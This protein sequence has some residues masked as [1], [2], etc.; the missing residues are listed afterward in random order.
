MPMNYLVPSPLITSPRFKNTDCS[1]HALK[2]P[3][4]GGCGGRRV[5]LQRTR[6]RNVLLH[7][8]PST[9]K[10]TPVVLDPGFADREDIAPTNNSKTAAAR[11][12]AR[13]E[14]QRQRRL[15]AAARRRE[16]RARKRA[17][18]LAK[19]KAVTARKGR[20]KKL[21]GYDDVGLGCAHDGMHGYSDPD[22]ESLLGDFELAEYVAQQLGEY[23]ELP[24]LGGYSDDSWVDLGEYGLD[25]LGELGIGWEGI[26][27]GIASGVGST[28]SQQAGGGGGAQKV[29][30]PDGTQA[31]VLKQLA[32]TQQQMQRRQ[33]L[34]SSRASSSR[35]GGL[36]GATMPLVIA[37]GLLLVMTMKK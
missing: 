23:G 12:A 17:A 18:T 13:L 29:T 19:R 4:Q 6:K 36:G 15:N 9:G 20:S 24:E 21:H 5:R 16:A 2:F 31:L 32:S 11:R 33:L 26:V 10:V 34:D 3:R 25:D 37:G 35:S 1:Q 7:H 14:A 27:G 22:V 8:N 30:T 28:L